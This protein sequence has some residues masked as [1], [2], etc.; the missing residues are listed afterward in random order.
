MRKLTAEQLQRRDAFALAAAL[1]GGIILLCDY[2]RAAWLEVPTAGWL[3]F[4]CGPISQHKLSEFIVCASWMFAAVMFNH[5]HAGQWPTWMPSQRYSK[6]LVWLCVAT[7][8][9]VVPATYA[10][11][12]LNLGTSPLTTNVVPRQENLWAWRG[13]L[14]V[15]ILAALA[16]PVLMGPKAV[17]LVKQTTRAI[18]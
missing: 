14:G 5:R 13:Y 6:I 4:L 8:L 15:V 7:M 1:I 18:N 16:F 9:A 2:G 10:W 12:V 17:R 3:G 11:T